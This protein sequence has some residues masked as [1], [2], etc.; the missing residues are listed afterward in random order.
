MTRR[1]LFK[2]GAALAV[3]P[4]LPAPA[5]TYS[6]TLGTL[7]LTAEQITVLCRLSGEWTV[8]GDWSKEPGWI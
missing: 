7:P 8:W 3:S 2:L 6:N 4:A 1:E 5:A